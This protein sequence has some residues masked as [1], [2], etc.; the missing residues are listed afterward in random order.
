MAPERLKVWKVKPAPDNLRLDKTRDKCLLTLVSVSGIQSVFD[1]TWNRGKF[2]P[3]GVKAK[4][5][6]RAWTG[7]MGDFE[8]LGIEMSFN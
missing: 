8:S 4:A 2:D 6:D 1:L 7:Q 3:L 5:F